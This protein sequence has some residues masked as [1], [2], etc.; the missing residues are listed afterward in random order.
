MTTRTNAGV[1]A[2]LAFVAFVGLAC[3]GGKG[4]LKREAPGANATPLAVGDPAETLY[5]DRCAGCHGASG[6][7]DGSLSVTM[8]VKPRDFTDP[9]WQAAGSDERVRTAILK[10]G[11]AVGGSELMPG[12]PDLE[13]RA[14]VLDAL[15][16]KVRAFHR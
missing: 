4:A 6:R 1:L 2:T 11:K 14:D 8:P 7:G 9:A 5:R 12:S 16:K 10:G 3:D 15:V 13:K